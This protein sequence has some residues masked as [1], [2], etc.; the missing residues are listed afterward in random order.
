MKKI[1]IILCFIGNAHFSFSQQQTNTF[2][3]GTPIEKWFKNDTKLKL[4]DLGN[5]YTITNFGVKNDSTI[6]QTRALQA[7]IDKAGAGGG[8]VIVIPKGV[9]LSGALFFKPKTALYL[10]KG[11]VLKGS[12]D[13][14]DYPIL[15]SRME[16]QNLDYFPA[17]INAYGVDYF[18]ISGHGTI[19]GNGKKFWEAFWKRR[20]ENP[21]CTNLE[22]SRPRLI[23]VWN[24]NNV[25]FQDV[26]LINS[27]FWTNHFYK[28]TNIKLLGLYIF[29]PHIEIKAP[30]T[31]AVDLDVCENVL[32]KDCYMSVNDDAVALKGGKG[33][34]ADQ[35]K[36]NGPNKNIIIEDCTF[37][38]CH[39]ALTNGSEAIHNRNVIF[40][41]S[42]I[43]GASRLLWLKMRPDTLQ[44][45]EYILVENIKGEAETCLAVFAWRQFYDLKGRPDIPLSYGERI[46]LRNIE[47]KCTNFYGVEK[48]PNVRL[49][50]FKFENLTIETSRTKIDKTIIDGLIL[51]NVYLNK[52]LIE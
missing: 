19:N 4:K 11:A 28:C 21:E 22:V 3:D 49:S 13:I 40:R 46:T 15:P 45:Y 50:N 39:S 17:L 8:G 27:G 52:S 32:I 33:P 14:A 24:S 51:K 42:K 44:R 7:V 16:G 48:D 37:G 20:S 31:D 6:V 34:Y 12:D 38:F 35:D 36:N 9:F 26:K 29:S 25:Q 43:E 18:S 1:L 23:F 5:Q 2:P 47:L 41:N 10:E 30:S